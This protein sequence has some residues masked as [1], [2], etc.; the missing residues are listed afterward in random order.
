MN[1]AYNKAAEGAWASVSV[2]VGTLTAAVLTALNVDGA[3]SAAA[4]VCATALARA[5]LAFVAS[6]FGSRA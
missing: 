5:V 4:A 3:V 2:A 6:K 1:Y